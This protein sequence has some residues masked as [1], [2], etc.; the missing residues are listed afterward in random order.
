MD[1]IITLADDGDAKAEAP[2]P[3][4]VTAMQAKRKLREGTFLKRPYGQ[5]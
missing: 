2:C 3:L 4:L 1:E 5:E